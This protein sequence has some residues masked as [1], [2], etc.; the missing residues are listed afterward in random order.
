MGKWAQSRKR[1]GGV[2]ATYTLPLPPAPTLSLDTGELYSDQSGTSNPGGSIKLYCS[3]LETGPFIEQTSYEWDTLVDV[4]APTDFRP[5]FWFYTRTE[6]N[7]TD[8]TG[9]GPESNHLNA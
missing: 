5:F 6:G 7:G 3:I 2:A 4:G 1:G 8:Y 9:V